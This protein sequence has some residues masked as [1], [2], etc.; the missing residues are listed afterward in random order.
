LETAWDESDERLSRGARLELKRWENAANDA[1]GGVEAAYDRVRER[2][3]TEHIR[4]T[5]KK[6]PKSKEQLAAIKQE[7]QG[8]GL[9]AGEFI[10]SV[11]TRKGGLADLS[12]RWESDQAAVKEFAESW[13]VPVGGREWE[14]FA[15]KQKGV[16]E[17]RVKTRRGFIDWMIDMVLSTSDTK[18]DNTKSKKGGQP[19]SAPRSG[20]AVGSTGTAGGGA[21]QGQQ[22]RVP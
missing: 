1:A 2:L 18:K 8:E 6:D 14:E 20:S 15:K 13:G 9:N 5:M 10:E 4:E 19:E 21:G 7:F 12:G 11:V 16:Y 22:H 17:R 3:I